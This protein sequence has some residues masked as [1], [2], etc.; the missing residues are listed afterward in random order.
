MRFEKPLTDSEE[1]D[2]IEIF[3]LKKL[4][5]LRYSTPASY[6]FPAPCGRRPIRRE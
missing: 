4:K 2:L 6:A 5:K 1:K 3:L